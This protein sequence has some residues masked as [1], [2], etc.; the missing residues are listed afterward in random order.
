MT[1]TLATSVWWHMN[2]YRYADHK[3]YSVHVINCL[4]MWTSILQIVGTISIGQNYANC[5][6]E[7]KEYDC[8]N[9]GNNTE[10]GCQHEMVEMGSSFF[11]SWLFGVGTVYPMTKYGWYKENCYDKYG[12]TIQPFYICMAWIVIWF[13]IYSKWI[14][15]FLTYKK[16][17]RIINVETYE[18]GETSNTPHITENRF[19]N[20]GERDENGGY[21]Y[22]FTGVMV[23]ISD[24][25]QPSNGEKPPDYDSI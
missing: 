4:I 23:E 9:G 16:N 17:E 15:M 7:Y 3:K 13:I 20:T 1:M 11:F 18:A 6:A 10:N 22:E 14:Y 21:I 19:F 24:V 8:Y 25:H 12:Y 5:L 2:Y